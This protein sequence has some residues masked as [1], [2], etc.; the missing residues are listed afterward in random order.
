[1]DLELMEARLQGI[2]A[3]SSY[4]FRTESVTEY[5]VSS[6][7]YQ[8]GWEANGGNNGQWII[9]ESC[10]GGRKQQIFNDGAKYDKD[11]AKAK[12]AAGCNASNDCKFAN[13]W[14]VGEGSTTT[15]DLIGEDCGD[16][17]NASSSSG[18]ELYIKS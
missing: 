9:G 5:A 6:D 16:W 11:T 15:C 12:C 2:V 4:F 18:Y 3:E 8:N 17:E 10:P 1:M 7:A 14:W 13:L